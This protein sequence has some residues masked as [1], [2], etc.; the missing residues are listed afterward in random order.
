MGAKAITAAPAHRPNP[1]QLM[2]RICRGSV[3]PQKGACRPL[4]AHLP[5]CAVLLL[6][7]GEQGVLLG[8]ETRQ[9]LALWV[10]DF[11]TKE[12]PARM[13][14]RLLACRNRVKP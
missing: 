2:P 1:R 14:E 11:G 6:P 12:S 5:N 9:V 3:C 4:P 7:Q 8:V 13:E 10:A